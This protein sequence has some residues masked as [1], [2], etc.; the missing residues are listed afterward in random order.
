MN[1]HNRQMIE[2]L[3]RTAHE[4]L[5]HINELKSAHTAPELETAQEHLYADAMAMREQSRALERHL[6]E[7]AQ[8][9]YLGG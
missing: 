9:V 8:R 1:E 4:L 2:D 7:D 6:N 3:E 5:S